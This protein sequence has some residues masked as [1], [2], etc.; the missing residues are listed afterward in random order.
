MRAS[1]GEEEPG[2]PTEAGHPDTAAGRMALETKALCVP[3]SQRGSRVA[4][5]QALP[6][7]LGRQSPPHRGLVGRGGQRCERGC[8]H[9]AEGAGGAGAQLG[10]NVLTPT[11]FLWRLDIP[12]CDLL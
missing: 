11:C 3:R 6:E 10:Q 2:Y 7:A 8:G 5:L 9:R 12:R 1:P 4:G